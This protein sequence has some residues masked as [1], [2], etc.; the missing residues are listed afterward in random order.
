MKHQYYS[1]QVEIL[2]MESESIMI[3]SSD[4]TNPTLNPAPERKGY[5][6]HSVHP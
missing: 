1:A 2:K 4:P 3:P 6:P 5:T